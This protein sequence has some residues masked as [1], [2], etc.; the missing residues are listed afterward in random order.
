MQATSASAGRITATGEW[1][2]PFPS[3]LSSSSAA[4]SSMSCPAALSASATSAGWP[5]ATL[6]TSSLA[7]DGCST[8]IP[9]PSCYLPHQPIGKPSATSSPANASTS[10]RSARKVAWFASCCSTPRFPN[11]AVLLLCPRRLLRLPPP[12]L[13]APS[14]QNLSGPWENYALISLQPASPLPS[15]AIQNGQKPTAAP[16]HPLRLPALPTANPSAYPSAP[17][18]S[19]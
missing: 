7:A 8:S 4:S 14:N 17:I 9:L 12:S 3:M 11:S 19:P 15:T 16:A 10:A 5:T 13:Q 18:Q 1:K 2:R 6:K